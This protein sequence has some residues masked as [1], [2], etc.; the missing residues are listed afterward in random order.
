MLTLAS[1][2]SCGPLL[3]TH[4]EEF[5]ELQGKHR[6]YFYYIDLQVCVCCR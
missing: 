2:L 4:S 5:Y 3:V 6:R 1:S